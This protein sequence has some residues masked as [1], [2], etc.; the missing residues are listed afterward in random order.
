MERKSCLFALSI[1]CALY[2]CSV[3][4]RPSFMTQQE[5]LKAK[6]MLQGIWVDADEE[7]VAF[8]AK[9]DTIYYPDSTSQPVYFKIIED[10]LYLKGQNTVKYP[11]VKQAPHLF[12]FKNQAGDVIKLVRS[13]DPDDKYNFSRVSPITLNQ[14]LLIKRDS[15]VTYKGK[16]YHSY[17]QVNPTTYKVIKTSYNDDGVEVDN[18]YHDNIIHLSLFQGARQ[19]YS[20]N[21]YKRDFRTKI[22]TAFLKASVLSDLVF[23]KVDEQGFHYYASLCIPD[24]PSSYLVEIQ[25]LFDGRLKMNLV[26]D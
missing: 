5:D 13:D 16:R 26:G 4:Q 3:R 25:I 15:V 19:L 12:E 6:K 11:I 18:V 17:I 20:H 10:T 9:G 1:A 8:R 14:N 22:P 7:D 21:I 24:S 2:S 23:Q